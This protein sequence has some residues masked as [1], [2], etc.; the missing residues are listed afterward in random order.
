M[1]ALRAALDA[2]ATGSGRLV[3]LHGEAG[4][5]K[6]HLLEEFERDAEA[7]GAHV[8]WGR[9]YEREGAP[10]FW[11]W[12]QA[13]RTEMRSRAPVDVRAMLG[14]AASDLAHLVPELQSHQPDLTPTPGLDTPQGRFRLFESVIA[15]LGRLASRAPLVVLLDDLQRADRPSLLLLEFVAQA[16]GSLRVLFVVAYR[17]PEHNATDPCAESLR[18]L[19]RESATERVTLAGLDRQ[20]VASLVAEAL[21]VPAPDPL[22]DALHGVTHGNPLFL[23]EIVL[24][25]AAHWRAAGSAGVASTALPQGVHEA[26][27][28]HITS[29]S[30]RASDVLRVAAVLGQEFSLTTLKAVA[31]RP[32]EELVAAIDEAVAARLLMEERGRPGYCR[33]AH[34]L[35]RDGLYDALDPGARRALH[36]RAGEVL[37]ARG[38][39]DE[40]LAEIAHHFAAAGSIH[41]GIARAGHY[42][43]RAADRALA[44]LAFEEAERLYALA[45]EL[46]EQDAPG[47]ARTR[48]LLLVAL[49]IAQNR[50]GGLDR[51]KETFLRAAANARS[52]GARDVLSRAAL[53]Y[54]GELAFPE[55]GARD[56]VHIALLEEALTAWGNDDGTL[57]ARL[58]VHLATALYF[59]DAASRRVALC[60]RAAAM[61]RRLNDPYTL[62][63]VLLATHGATS[64]ADNARERMGMADALLRLARRSGDRAVAFRARAARV[65]DHLE[66]GEMAAADEDLEGCAELAR[67]LRQ[68]SYDGLVTVFRATRA[69]V[70]GRLEEAETLA[71]AILASGR[72]LGRAVDAI[73]AL[74]LMTIRYLQGRIGDLLDPIRAFVAA[75]PG[76][77]AAHCGLALIFVS[78][79]LAAEARGEVEQVMTRGLFDVPRDVA[80]LPAMV[81]LAE[82]CALLGDSVWMEAMYDVLLP[83]AGLCVVFGNG[84]SFL[85]SVSHYLGLLARRLGRDGD[86]A[87]HLERALAV[88]AAMGAQPWLALSQCEYGALLL[89]R[90]GA[91]EAERGDELVVQALAT[92]EALGMAALAARARALRNAAPGWSTA[93]SEVLP[94]N[95]ARGLTGSTATE[96]DTAVFRTEGDS[97]TIVYAGRAIRLRDTRGLRYLAQLL[98][99]PGRE[100]HAADLV[101]LASGDGPGARR[102][103]GRLDRAASG[104]GD[105][106]EAIDEQARREYRRHLESLHDQLEEAEAYNDVDRARRLRAEINA[107]AHALS[108]T[109]RGRRV[110]AHAERARL[111]V[112]KGIKA[113]LAKIQVSHPA[114]GRHLTATVRRGYTCVYAPDPRHPITWAR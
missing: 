95:E 94:V 57:H 97:W 63:E 82:A 18:Q 98:W 15:V 86:A 53:G 8:L 1:T 56:D 88:H 81:Q 3:L 87:R 2:A 26:I 109:P 93:T 68:P 47:D 46:L 65:W 69:I 64:A 111:T 107:I 113:A 91:K 92:A 22:V 85:G 62:A 84:I 96:A 16:L 38:D 25:L 90:G 12:V 45:L 61:A 34:A 23:G 66:L 67:E 14:A 13:M 33:F 55:A 5:G 74:Q 48:A 31:D 114:L 76:I 6:T 103:A 10:P 80:F 35:I 21:G 29:L 100:L 19:V 75:N 58:L 99:H 78:L 9:C 73:F 51:A 102:A 108:A 106:G 27:A 60:D 17:D 40:H 49:G 77:P 72:W 32:D 44:L 41:G 71:G 52:V 11:P 24:E 20:A 42:A 112:T 7:R 43:R 28:R 4:I 59:T 110:A 79:G 104:L 70:K 54:G 101:R 39:E 89:A 30:P 83:Y 105:A 50:A 36:R 37:A